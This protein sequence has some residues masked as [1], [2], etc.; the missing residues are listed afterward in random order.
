MTL[1]CTHTSTLTDPYGQGLAA[2]DLGVDARCPRDRRAIGTARVQG[3]AR[4]EPGAGKSDERQ[5]TALRI[6]RLRDRR[7]A[8]GLSR[9]YNQELTP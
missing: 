9:Q 1:A 3:A 6:A 5:P 2:G 7:K 4:W 8:R